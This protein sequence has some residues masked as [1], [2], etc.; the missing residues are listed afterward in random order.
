MQVEEGKIKLD[1]SLPKTVSKQ[2]GVFYNPVMKLN[3]DV[4]ILLLNALG[5][6]DIQI[7]DPMAG[8]GVRALRFMKELD[9]SIVKRLFVNDY[10]DK[11]VSLIKE[12]MKLNG[13]KA[14]SIS[15][16]CTDANLFLLQNKGFDYIDVDPFGTPNPF[17]DSAI[18]RISRDGVLAVTATD[19]SALCGTYINACRRKYWA[20]PLHNELMHETGLRILIRKVQLIGAQYE[21][22]LTPIFCYSL[23]HYFRIFFRCD[24]GKSKV[25]KMIK[26]HGMFMESGPMWLGKLWDKKLVGKMKKSAEDKK[27]KKLLDDIYCEASVDSVGFYD[28]HALCKRNKLKEIPKIDVLIANLKKKG[29]KAARTH[30]S[31][32]GVRTDADENVL[33]KIIS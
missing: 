17:L 4:S 3:R 7:S 16:S 28:I 27:V 20:E 25:D 5:K 8:S 29:Y 30:F 24:K 19:T 23:D 1:I 22:A 15:I 32:H 13:I 21:K 10:S 31:G 14:G 11:A 9:K 33:K 18:K 6:K 12:N 26:D 2:M